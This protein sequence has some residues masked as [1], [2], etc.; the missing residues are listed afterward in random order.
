MGIKVKRAFDGSPRGF[1]VTCRDSGQTA[2][3]TF[4]TRLEAEE[5]LR[6]VQAAKERE[7]MG[8]RA[9][10][11]EA[12]LRDSATA[13]L[14]NMKVREVL[15]WHASFVGTPV[16]RQAAALAKTRAGGVRVFELDG[17]WCRAFCERLL[18]PQDGGAK[19]GTLARASIVSSLSLIKTACARKADDL[20]IP[21]I[22][23]P[24]SYEHLP[25]SNKFRS[26]RERR[27]KDGEEAL[28]RAALAYGSGAAEAPSGSVA[29][30][31][32]LVF[33]FAIETC[34]SR[35]QALLLPWSE[36]DD[37]AAAWRL[38][39][40]RSK[41]GKPLVIELS[42]K[43]LAT[44]AELREDRAPA[45]ALVFH[46]I[47]SVACFEKR[48]QDAMRRA[49][50]EDLRFSDLRHEGLMRRVEGAALGV[51]E[52]QR[53]FGRSRKTVRRYSLARPSLEAM[54][55]AREFVETYAQL[56]KSA[57]ATTPGSPA[58]ARI[59]AHMDALLEKRELEGA[60]SA[61]DAA[62]ARAAFPKLP[63]RRL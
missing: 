30:H 52:L 20:G 59:V 25:K 44:L 15:D 42:A 43:A 4:Q 2:C 40:T 12:A 63:P 48:W 41:S 9:E 60:M 6:G 58:R 18:R 51:D 31:C 16:A 13:P 39:A 55:R 34:A 8:K 35:G 53:Q 29:R 47:S 26:I 24:L 61:A 33:D 1:E 49:G 27:L 22:P 57:R 19:G 17:D 5:F 3:R 38:P 28:V 37:A 7:K 50:I 54:E 45:S 32:Q 14:R 21:R 56:R 10:A 23:L 62:A 46:R 36:I 11:F